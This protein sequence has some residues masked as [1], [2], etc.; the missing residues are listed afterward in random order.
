MCA[1]MRACGCV[2]TRAHAHACLCVRERE[3]R[4]ANSSTAAWHIVIGNPNEHLVPRGKTGP[5]LSPGHINTEAWSLYGA[6][7]AI[8]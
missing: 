1:C 5:T 7:N 6:D 4:N 2:C 3:N 8:P